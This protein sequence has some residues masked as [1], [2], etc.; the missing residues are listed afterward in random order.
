MS[1]R[2]DLEQ[3]ESRFRKFSAI[4]MD[5]IL[6]EG[7]L[8]D[9]LAVNILEVSGT[10]PVISGNALRADCSLDDAYITKDWGS[11]RSDTWFTF[12]FALS[13]D[14]LAIIFADFTGPDFIQCLASD[15]A[16]VANMWI[17]AALGGCW[18][19]A[20]DS[21]VGPPAPIAEVWQTIEINVVTGD[22]RD[23]YVSGTFIHTMTEPYGVDSRK[24][25]IGALSGFVKG[26]NYLKNIKVGTFR[27]G[28]DLFSDDFGSGDFSA[29]DSVYGDCTVVP[30]PYP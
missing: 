5:N 20:G 16:D 8:D 27:G 14:F 25:V 29:W 11:D 15:D 21:V 7:N 17:R 12:D 24:I 18:A 23:F 3:L 30:D 26:V 2:E 6:V 28:T 1:F 13:A 22:R 10:Q 19:C 9:G 4:G